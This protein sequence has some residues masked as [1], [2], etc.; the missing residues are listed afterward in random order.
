[1]F[2]HISTDS[3]NETDVPLY[4]PPLR[5]E[6]Q[7]VAP[8]AAQSAPSLLQEELAH[9]RRSGLDILWGGDPAPAGPATSPVLHVEPVKKGS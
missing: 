3:V 4:P 1:M 7:L 8:Q 5:P 9:A 2:Q 6:A